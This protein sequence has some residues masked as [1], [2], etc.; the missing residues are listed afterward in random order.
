M[1]LR[2]AL[3]HALLSRLDLIDVRVDFAAHPNCMCAA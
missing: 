1:R 2:V 3:A